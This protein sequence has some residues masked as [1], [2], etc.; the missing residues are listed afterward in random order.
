MNLIFRVVIHL[1]SLSKN[2]LFESQLEHGVHENLTACRL[3]LLRAQLHISQQEL[4]KH[5]L[6][7]LRVVE[8]LQKCRVLLGALISKNL[9]RKKK[10]SQFCTCPHNLLWLLWQQHKFEVL[11]TLTYPVILP[12]DLLVS[13]QCCQHLFNVSPRGGCRG[14]KRQILKHK[15][16]CDSYIQ[17]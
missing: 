2:I 4:Q 12:V 5:S 3:E 11:K 14:T 7:T 6:I 17:S 1:T 10:R 9:Q 16:L 13:K 15:P 8:S